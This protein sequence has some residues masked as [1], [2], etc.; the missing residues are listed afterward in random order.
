MAS[1]WSYRA[2]DCRLKSAGRLVSGGTQG[3]FI[4]S[5]SPSGLV[6]FTH[7]CPVYILMRDLLLTQHRG[8]TVIMF[9]F[10]CPGVGVHATIQ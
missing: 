9:L 2:V 8:S 3:R 5:G 1:H 6:V 10:T 4:L 7:C